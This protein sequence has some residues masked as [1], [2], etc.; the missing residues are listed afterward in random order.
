MPNSSATKAP[1]AR[2]LNPWALLVV[3]IVVGI[4]LWATYRNE[5][6]FRPKGGQPDEVSA[7]YAEVLLAAHP[8]NNELRTQLLDLLIQLGDYP[9]AEKHLAQWSQPDP[10]L[11]AYYRLQLDALALN[12]ST[13]SAA[14]Q[15]LAER[16]KA[17]D[18]KT[19]PSP[20]L[21][22]LA[23]LALSAQAPGLAADAYTE[24]ARRDP[25]QRDQWLPEAA[26]WY[27][28]S[29]QPGR[30]ADLYVQLL[31]AS[32]TP[33]ERRQF[34]EKAFKSLV[35]ADRGD[36]AAE[37]LAREL[38]TQPDALDAA[39]LD[40]GVDVAVAHNRRD[41]AEQFFSAWR[42][43]QPDSPE[44][45]AKEFKQRL[46][47]GDL[48][49]AYAVGSQLLELH[50]DDPLLLEQMAHIAEWQGDSAS[51]LGYWISL[52]KLRNNPAEFEHTWRLAMQTYDF[53]R[54]I[55][56]LAG[57][58][59]TRA[60][61][62]VELDALVYAEESRG[63]PEQGEQWLRRYVGKYPK[64]RLAWVRLLQNLENT[65][66]YP[67]RLAV[68]KRFAGLYPL[69]STERVDWA[70]NH[71]KLFDSPSAWKVITA[72]DGN[73]ID[74]FNY[75][76]SRAALAWDLE[77][78]DEL[79]LALEKMLAIKGSL[80]SGDESELIALYRVRDPRKAL[81]LTV[82][83][84][85]REHNPQRLIAALQLAQELQDWPLV[86]DLLKEADQYPD[87]SDRSQVLAARGALAVQQG[88]TDEALRLYRLGLS[89]FPDDNT[90]RERLMWLYVDLGR[91]GELKPLLQQWRSLARGDSTLW[92][93]FAA[94]SQL[95]GRNTEALA[96]YRLYLR[97][98]PQ[99]WMVQAAY[100]DALEGAGYADSAQRLR[101]KLNR[102]VTPEQIRATPQGY[103]TW[104]RLVA[105]S[106][107]SRKA[108]NKAMQWQ[109]G[110][111]PML[112]LWF[113]QMLAR[114]DEIN[115][116]T[117]KDDWL[118]WA[119]ARGLKVNRYEQIQEAL[120]GNNRQALERLVASDD[121][122]PAQ[123]VEAL[124]SLGRSGEA[125]AVDLSALGEDQP[126]SLREQLRRQAIELTERTPQGVQIAWDRQDYGGLVFNGPRLTAARYLND[127]WY[128]KL[129]L[130]Q[131]RY[132]GDVLDPSRL[133][134][135]TN[136]ELTLQRQLE[137]GNYKLI[138]DS[139]LRKDDDR[140]G[141]GASRTWQVD[142]GNELDVG[143][144]WHRKNEDSGYMRT[145]GRQDDVWVGGRH[146]YSARDQ[147]SWSL[148]QRWF[149]TRGGD[150][151]GNG[152]AL[153]IEFDH[154]L[155]FEGPNWQLRSGIDYQQNSLNN[156]SLPNLANT[157]GG[158]ID[159][160]G[161]ELDN[162]DQINSQTLLQKHYGQ[163]FFGSSWRRG[164]PGA[165][166]RTRGQY[167]W[168]VDVSTGWQ[169]TDN[170]INYAI[171]TGI[172]TEV[173]GD[174]ELAVTFG[175]QSAPQGGTGQSGGTA[176]VSYSVRFGR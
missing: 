46:A 62:D 173:I 74:D 34:L 59:N 31:D 149:S 136:T 17:F 111:K 50:P 49:G 170:T 16:F 108:L 90:F 160:I 66:Q 100:A 75:W 26:K 96:W 12:N 123:R 25:K 137:N 106:Y 54:G 134:N 99:D 104:L 165:L 154:T 69:T 133:G 30:A 105:S 114:L 135:E 36:Q 5:D 109:D 45:L 80:N 172:G 147:L 145:F 117:Q 55:P 19:L 32:Q 68:W 56:L 58:M 27:Q 110:S 28:A 20:Q 150:D 142:S 94:A 91:T 9:R 102:E 101:L 57:I 157:L 164:F 127:N 130:E 52:S 92:L 77:L 84:W 3:A 21:E 103:A 128:A 2:L 76:Q 118:A 29:E 152:Q 155:Q 23:T 78:D 98:N 64:H 141:L 1:R 4:L 151:L 131:G 148:A 15:A 41:L 37:L 125:L 153:K 24:L 129:V 71:L 13:D 115:Q 116:S 87:A 122:D 7:S 33:Q 53:D 51:A 159:L 79:Q 61:S 132:S 167:T 168:L 144:D 70:N 124:N 86:V 138:F 139:S 107:S 73:K 166:N 93:P 176:G 10:V 112:Q 35:A 121:L 42:K 95:L 119:R 174:D 120:R 18:Y 47:F 83:S 11:K 126:A 158:G 175:Y 72:V 140:N 63:T 146:R 67:Q 48:E 171:S 82:D 6:A 163:L 97:S 85:R 162:P 143:A 169:W 89:R 65:A 8:E 43:L 40:Q 44:V 81:Q 14:L 39:L 113:D 38:A 22:R 156:R 88:R 60:L 161:A